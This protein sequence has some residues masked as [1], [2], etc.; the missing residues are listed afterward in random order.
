WRRKNENNN[1]DPDPIPC[2]ALALALL[3]YF[4]LPTNEDNVQRNDR[5]TPSRE[6]FGDV[7]SKYIPG[8][9]EII[10]NELEQF[11]NTDHFVIPHG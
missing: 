7:L 8:F 9:V 10:Q 6:E 5:S 1:D 3:Y 4:R 2:I 11:V